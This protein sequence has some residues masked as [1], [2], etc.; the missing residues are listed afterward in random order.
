MI[1]AL[2][3]YPYA[4]AIYRFLTDTET[5]SPLAISIQAPW[6]GG[7]T[8]LMRM[9]QAQLGPKHPSLQEEKKSSIEIANYES[10][11]RGPSRDGA[12]GATAAKSAAGANV[13]DINQELAGNQPPTPKLNEEIRKEKGRITV[14]L[15]AWKYES[16]SQIWAGLAD[17]IISQVGNRLSIVERERFFFRLH[18]KRLDVGKIR[19]RITNDLVST[20]WSELVRLWWIYLVLPVATLLTYELGRSFIR[21]P[22]LSIAVGG[23]ALIAAIHFVVTRFDFDKKPAKLT[24]GEFLTVP[25]YDANLGFVHLVTEDLKKALELIPQEHPVVIFIDD[26]DRCSPNKV[27]DVIEAV[28]LFLA[29]EFENCMFVLGIDAEVVAAALNKSHG[30]V[31]AQMPSYAQTTSIGWRFMDKFVQLPFVIPAPDPKRIGPVCPVTSRYEGAYRS[32]QPRS[33]RT[34]FSFG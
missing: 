7:K 13:E 14:W 16:T 1:D 22:W 15:N 20:F 11:T 28:N 8:S 17:A 3:Y 21:L 10:S 34:C 25:D 33:T 32:G 24:L 4:Y 30:D 12:V 18:L 26:L 9:I 6:G 27:A 2:G 23:N 5:A 29:G 31:F 19:N